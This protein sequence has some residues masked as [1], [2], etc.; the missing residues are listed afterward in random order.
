[1]APRPILVRADWAGEA[2]F[3]PGGQS[4]I[5]THI[6]HFLGQAK[7]TNLWNEIVRLAEESRLRNVGL[8]LLGAALAGCGPSQQAPQPAPKGKVVIKGSNTVGEELGPRLIAEFKKTHPDVDIALETKGSASGYWGLIGGWCDIAAASRDIAKDEQEQ[9]QARGV[10]LQDNVIGCDSVAVIVNAANPLAD[11]SREQVRDLFTGAVRNWKELGGADLA[12]HMYVRNPNSG[13]YFGFREVAMQDKPYA[14]NEI[15]FTTYEGIAGAVAKDPGGIGYS[16]I[17]PSSQP[18][19]KTVTIGGVPATPAAVKEG[20]C[21]YARRLHLCTNKTAEAP[22]AT[23]F[24]Q[25]VASSRG[26]E[27]LAELGFVPNK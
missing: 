15:M 18:G 6:S 19:T 9:A 20:K 13:T 23:E 27:I 1:M 11:L 8:I 10:E 22:T 12:V 14:T 2:S 7:K 24:V 21:P 17:Q 4:K 5:L 26:Q 3:Q 25:F 16:G